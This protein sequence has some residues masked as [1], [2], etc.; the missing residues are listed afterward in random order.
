MLQSTTKL[1]H[2]FG[3]IGRE[4]GKDKYNFLTDS[5]KAVIAFGMTP[6]ELVEEAEKFFEKAIKNYFEKEMNIIIEAFGTIKPEVRS[7]FIRQFTL[8]L[9]DGATEQGKM[10]A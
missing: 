2:D 9:M 8:G 10:I 5:H 1:I 6:I 7:E 3:C 4:F